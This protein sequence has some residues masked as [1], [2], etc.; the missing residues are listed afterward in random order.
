MLPLAE[1][2]S[3]LPRVPRITV[4]GTWIRAIAFTAL[5]GSRDPLWADRAQQGRFSPKGSFAALYLASDEATARAEVEDVFQHRGF[6]RPVHL[7]SDIWTYVPVSGIVNGIIDLTDHTIQHSLATSVSELTGIWRFGNPRGVLPPTQLLGALAF[8][9]GAIA[10]FRYV[11]ART[12]EHGINH[13]IFV[14]RLRLGI[15]SLE[16]I[17]RAGTLS[18]RLP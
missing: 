16:V 11:S 14:D 5:M 18:R 9:L 1:L 4:H 17:D 2:A 15:D 10:G 7:P 13:V 6:A 3:V 12:P 8:E